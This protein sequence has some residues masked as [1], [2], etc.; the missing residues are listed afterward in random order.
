MFED[1]EM[2]EYVEEGIGKAFSFRF[3]LLDL[4]PNATLALSLRR[5][6]ASYWGYIVKVRRSSDDTEKDIGFSGDS[7]D[8]DE[9]LDFVGGGDGY[10][11]TWYDQSGHNRDA[12]NTNNNEQPKIVSS[13]QLI[14]LNNRPT[15]EFKESKYLRIPSEGNLDFINSSGFSFFLV[16]NSQ[17]TATWQ[18]P[19]SSG[20]FG[21]AWTVFFTQERAEMRL[22]GVAYGA[23]TLSAPKNTTYLFSATYSDD[24]EL[25]AYNNKTEVSSHSNATLTQTTPTIF[26]GKDQGPYTL[27]GQLNDV[28]LYDFEH[29]D[30]TNIENNL[31]SYYG[32]E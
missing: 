11:T 13:G 23:S 15:I 20:W 29:G 32:I 18:A 10:V 3:L 22:D 2:G 24:N 4:Y 26:I 17:S 12:T 19:I 30:K 1:N 21:Q 14:T 7:I 27:D 6:S 8:I 5:L 25:K 31:L 9:L 16:V 28:L